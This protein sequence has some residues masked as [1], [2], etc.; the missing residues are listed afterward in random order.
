ML[1]SAINNAQRTSFG[2]IYS[3]T[4]DTVLKAGEPSGKKEEIKLY[5]AVKRAS[6]LDKSVITSSTT[7]GFV[8][9][10]KGKDG[11][12]DIYKTYQVFDDF[13]SNLGQLETAVKDA[14]ALEK[15]SLPS[16]N[17]LKNGI[18]SETAKGIPEKYSHNHYYYIYDK[19]LN[20]YN[21]NF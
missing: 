20:G 4:I 17:P 21:T 11:K 13:K 3:Q 1:I 7:K 16:I 14:E 6:E 8:L 19:T 15:T 10:T 18:S 12:R 9:L 5:N 2:H